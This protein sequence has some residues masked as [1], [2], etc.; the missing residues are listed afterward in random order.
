MNKFKVSPEEVEEFPKVFAETI[1]VFKQHPGF[2]SAQVSL[3]VQ[4]SLITLYGNL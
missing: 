2:I 3:G 1:K 4:H